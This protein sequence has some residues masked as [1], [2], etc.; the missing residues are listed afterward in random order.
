MRVCIFLVTTFPRCFGA[1]HSQRF[2]AGQSRGAAMYMVLGTICD[3]QVVSGAHVKGE[4]NIT[5]DGLSRAISLSELN[6]LSHQARSFERELSHPRGVVDARLVS[7]TRRDV[8]GR[9]RV[10]NWA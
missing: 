6:F 4:D 10:L 5:C 9:F 8:Y 7:I 2:K 3:L 1:S